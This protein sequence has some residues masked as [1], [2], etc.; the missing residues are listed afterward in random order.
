MRM[1]GQKYVGFKRDG[2]KCVQKDLKPAREIGPKCSSS[3][4]NKS[5]LFFCS[6]LSEGD[7]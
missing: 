2:D 7:R 4:C 1:M 5:K 6:K 3:K